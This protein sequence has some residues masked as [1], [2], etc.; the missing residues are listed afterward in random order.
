MLVI[1]LTGGIGSGKSTV[2]KLFAEH[3]VPIIDADLIARELV[4]PEQPALQKIVDNFGPDVLLPNGSLDRHRLR[5]LVFSDQLLRKSLEKIL[6]PPIRQSMLERLEQVDDTPYVIL[7]IPLLIDTGHWEMIDQI[8]VVD[9]DEETQIERVMQR[10]GFTEKQAKA[11]IDNQVSRNNRLEAADQVIDNSGDITHLRNQVELLHQAYLA[12]SEDSEVRRSVQNN[13]KADVIFELPITERIRTLLRLEQLFDRTEHHID[14]ND[15]YAAHCVIQSLVEINGLLRGDIKGEVIQELERQHASLKRHIDFPGIDK[16]IL[17]DLLA[18]I[19]R[20]VTALHDITEQLDQYLQNDLLYNSV[21]Q[22]LTIPGGT[23]SF[24]LPI[25]THWLN[26]G[27]AKREQTLDAWFAPYLPLK[28][29]IDTCLGAIR[30]SADP[31]PCTAANGFYEHQL[32]R[33]T[34]IQLIKILVDSD[35]PYYPTIT[36]NKYRLNIRFMEWHPG[37][38]QS[39]QT[40][41]NVE[42]SLMLCGI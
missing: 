39:P 3:H 34:H 33:R 17:Q 18:R 14:H 24:D 38:S 13:S 36:A 19:E 10:D 41:S 40:K 35:L 7:V 32:K 9:A 1:G 22:R 8:L 15:T 16:S 20:N 4:E 29:A 23:C 25:Y 12:E 11:I 28:N 2:A 21:R 31:L 42:F 26:S 37:E 5:E 30:N 27:H 6:H